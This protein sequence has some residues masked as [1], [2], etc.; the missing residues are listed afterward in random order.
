M[1][2]QY[3]KPT[4]PL[5]V[6]A[7]SSAHKTAPCPWCQRNWRFNPWWPFV[8]MSA[9]TH[10]IPNRPFTSSTAKKQRL[11][12]W[13]PPS[14]R[15]IWQRG[16]PFFIPSL[17]LTFGSPTIQ[18]SVFDRSHVKLY[19]TNLGLDRTEKIWVITGKENTLLYLFGHKNTQFSIENSPKIILSLTKRQN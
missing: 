3:P 1:A 13:S 7:P 16:F 18:R 8:A 11:W 2:S 4:A 15:D 12:K 17:V 14:D 19:V 5:S 10:P 6:S 9:R